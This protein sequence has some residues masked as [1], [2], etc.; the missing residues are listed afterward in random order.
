MGWLKPGGSQAG[1]RGPPG[2]QEMRKTDAFPAVPHSLGSGFICH[3][4]AQDTNK[5]QK[6]RVPLVMVICVLID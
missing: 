3:L 2:V 6:K 1:V 4:A 5:A